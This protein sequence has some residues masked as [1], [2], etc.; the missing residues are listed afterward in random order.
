MCDCGGR[1]S[2]GRSVWGLSHSWKEFENPT[3][4]E[5]REPL[6]KLQ[7]FGQRWHHP[8]TGLLHSCVASGRWYLWAQVSGAAPHL[9]GAETPHAPPI[10][11]PFLIVESYSPPLVFV[12]GGLI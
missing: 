3:P 9:A 7:P 11:S 2:G 10:L 8:C 1:C 5:Q 6:A 4:T 12:L